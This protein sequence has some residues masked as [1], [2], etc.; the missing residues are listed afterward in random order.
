MP[1]SPSSAIL[2][3]RRWALIATFALVELAL[4]LNAYESGAPKLPLFILGS[5]AIVALTIMHAF[6]QGVIE[7]PPHGMFVLAASHLLLFLV[8]FIWSRD[9]SSSWD[10]LLFAFSCVTTFF[11]GARAFRTRDQL[12]HLFRSLEVVS[13]ILSLVGLIQ[14]VF[15][16]KLPIVFFVDPGRRIPSLSGN[17]IFFSSYLALMFPFTL[18]RTLAFREQGS[19]QGIRVTLLVLMTVLLFATQT[20]SSIFAFALSTIA[21]F[22]LTARYTRRRRSFM[23]GGVLLV[24]GILSVAIFQPRLVT[25]FA[26]LTEGGPQSSLER[27]MV[28]WK[29]GWDAFVA[30]PIVGHGIGS[31]ERTV[32]EYRSP[33]Y[34]RSASEDVVPHAHNE[35]LEIAV[36]Y[37]TVGLAIVAAMLVLVVRRGLHGVRSLQEWQRWISAGILCSILA[38]GVDN[39]GNVTLREPPIAILAWLFMGL[40]WSPALIPEEHSLVSIRV[41]KRHVLAAAVLG[42]WLLGALAYSRAAIR[43]LDAQIHLARGVLLDANDPGQA[44]LN[45]ELAVREDPMN[46]FA[47]SRLSQEYLRQQRWDSALVSLDQ[48]QQTSPFYPQSSL[49]RS[50]ALLHLGRY[51]ESLHWIANEL[52]QRNHPEAY[53][54]QAEAFRSMGNKEG[55]RTAVQQVLRGMMEWNQHPSVRWYCARLAD[56]GASTAER[57]TD[58][59][60]LDSVG[61][62][63]PADREFI[64]AL[65]RRR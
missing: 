47:R 55:E 58:N 64:D 10:P 28:F 11:A 19:R 30:S 8:S 6:M 41:P 65:E 49:M 2:H 3:L 15:G 51:S 35:L 13:A 61:R 39:L 25:R 29:A 60:L 4:W 17:S 22:A 7:F 1:P 57:S 9:P 62:A 44:L 5:S 26:Q 23:I 45:D 27:R 38:A 53:A 43:V 12:E 42:L 46:L 40:L 16:D 14:L 37:G 48:L 32:F 18:A 21:L 31:Y 50:Y 54:I 34:W 56:L 24:A 63:F 33:D 20:R 52:R 59:A 36:E